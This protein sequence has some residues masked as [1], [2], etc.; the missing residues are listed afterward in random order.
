MFCP[1]RSDKI[2]L[3]R[4]FVIIEGSPNVWSLELDLHLAGTFL[5]HGKC[6]SIPLHFQFIIPKESGEAACTLLVCDI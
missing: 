2:I 4:V 6:P 5:S 1:A 3:L